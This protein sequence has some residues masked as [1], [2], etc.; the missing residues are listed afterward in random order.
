MTL[1][2]YGMLGAKADLI[3]AM[4]AEHVKLNF[5]ELRSSEHETLK[6]PESSGFIERKSPHDSGDDQLGRTVSRTNPQAT[7]SQTE[8]G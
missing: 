3:V 8:C 5:H 4:S 6:P 1:H 2:T 7:E